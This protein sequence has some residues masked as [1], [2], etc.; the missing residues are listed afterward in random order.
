MGIQSFKT[1]K[2]KS[3]ERTV[4]RSKNIY[5]NLLIKI[6]RFLARKTKSNFNSV[7]LKRLFSSRFHQ[8]PI[9]LSRL[10]RYSDDKKKII[11]VVGKV[12]NDERSVDISNLTICA[13]NFSI[14]AKKRILE[15]GG[16]TLTFDQL[17][18]ICPTGK[19]TLL[20]RGTVKKKSI[21]VKRNLITKKVM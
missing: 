3:I 19:N 15:N 6:Y 2:K 14:A 10:V 1:N 9:S 11:V 21:K 4:T 18:T 16:K 5:L 7:I 17:A 20:L 12:L 8:S 13:L